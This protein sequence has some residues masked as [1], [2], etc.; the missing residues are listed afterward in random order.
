MRPEFMPF[1]GVI[2][3][4]NRVGLLFLYEFIGLRCY[5]S[6]IGYGLFQI[7]IL[8]GYNVLHKIEALT[9]DSVCA[10]IFKFILDMDTLCSFRHVLTA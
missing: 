7:R 4:G 3:R 5:V 1:A 8:S 10:T 9:S 6:L 2:E